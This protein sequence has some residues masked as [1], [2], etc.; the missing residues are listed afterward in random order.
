LG[1]LGVLKN[2]R[3]IAYDDAGGA[4][5]ARLWWMLR[6]L[7]H[8]DVR[9]LNGGIQAWQAAGLGLESERPTW[10]ADRY[11]F[12]VVND[13]GWIRTADLAQALSMGAQLV[14]AR[15]AKRYAG[16]EEPI[17]PVAGH[18]PGAVNLPFS[19]F[20]GADGRFLPAAAL[21]TLFADRLAATA[22]AGTVA[23]CGSGVT[24]CHLLL[25]MEHAGL[26]GGRLYVGSW[27]GWIADPARPVG[28]G[29]RP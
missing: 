25:A 7:G 28:R 4:I 1:R 14:D 17:D 10:S 5:A 13:A 11:E 27:S 21:R 22:G 2:S 6:W 29:S 15:A 26:G 20:L 9:V 3:V 8:A 12:A 23:M 19:E 16:E 18:V 24:A